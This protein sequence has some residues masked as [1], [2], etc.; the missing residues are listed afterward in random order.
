[1]Q[2][3]EITALCVKKLRIIILEVVEFLDLVPIMEYEFREGDHR[4]WWW[5]AREP[6]KTL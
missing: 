1:M 4:E 6:L 3:L 2:W 5:W